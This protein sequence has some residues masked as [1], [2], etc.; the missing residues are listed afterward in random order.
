MT[1]LYLRGGAVLSPLFWLAALILVGAALSPAIAADTI[2]VA[3]DQARIIKLPERA[4]T[5]VIGNPLIADLSL[6]P[7]GIAV[8]TGKSYGATNVIA[9][10]KSGA[11]LMEKAVEVEG[12]RDRIVFVYRGVTRETYSCTPD[13]SARI[14]PGDD[15]D[16]F[17]KILTETTTRSNQA[18][19]AGAGPQR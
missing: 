17:T 9:M 1:A 12:P 3:L 10:D 14:T 18:L 19:A 15:A 16:F 7:N 11:I 13:C 4:T 8:I 6:Q 5:V 2:P